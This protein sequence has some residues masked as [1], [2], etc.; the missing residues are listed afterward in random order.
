MRIRTNKFLNRIILSFIFWVI[1]LPIFGQDSLNEKPRIRLFGLPAAYF[2]PETG[3]AGGAFGVMSFNWNKDTLL[4]QISNITLGFAITTKKQ[5]LF[6]MPFNLL[7]K[8]NTYLTSGEI[9][10]Y[11][12]TYFFYGI[13]NVS[14][15]AEEKAESFRVTF[16]RLRLTALK[17]VSKN[18]YFG[19]RGSFDSYSDMQLSQNSKIR[20]DSL[21]GI[22]TGENLGFGPAFLLDAR[23]SIFYPRR[24][25]LIDINNTN[26]LGKIVSDYAFSRLLVD[27]SVFIS[28]FKKSVVG[29]NFFYQQNT[30]NVPFYHLSMI[31]GGKKLRG[32]FEG[33]FREKY[34]WQTQLEWRQEFLKNWGAAAFIGIGWV[35]PNWNSLQWKNQHVGYGVGIRYKLNKKDHINIRFDVG[36]SKG[37]VYP[38]LTLGEA[39]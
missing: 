9:G 30:G 34:A 24:G 19:F 1:I 7:L 33:E 26:D 23:S 16:P 36:F 14:G 31:G 3:F 13:G 6:Y 37:K 10:Y 18:M 20:K 35:A 15:T 11:K 21:T 39:F 22:Q 5:I 38:Y 8:N 28:P 12:Y 27:M 29:Y 2:T 4:A 32:Q 17:K 25:V